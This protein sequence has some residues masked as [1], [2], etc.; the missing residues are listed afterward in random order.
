LPIILEH[1]IQ[2]TARPM[3]RYPN[4]SRHITYLL[5][6]LHYFGYLPGLS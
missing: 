4:S 1:A 2:L 6:T 3:R 5:I